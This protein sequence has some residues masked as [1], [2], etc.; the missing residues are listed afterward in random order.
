MIALTASA[1]LLGAC[2]SSFETG[3]D[4]AS[5]L[6]T[7]SIP[8]WAG[9]EPKNMPARSAAPPAYPAVNAP[10]PPRGEPAL[11]AEEQSRAVADLVAARN[12]AAA[13]A[14]AAHQENEDIAADE[15]LSLARGKY[16][17]EASPRDN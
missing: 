13:Q 14:K 3:Q 16:A 1:V 10:V 12:R 6:V 2:A 4:R 17:G 8:K 7:D 15:G 5:N 11:T 9:G